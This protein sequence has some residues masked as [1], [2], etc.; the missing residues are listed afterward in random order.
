VVAIAIGANERA[1]SDATSLLSLVV[2]EFSQPVK[3]QHCERFYL[4]VVSDA[5]AVI[6][7]VLRRNAL[8]LQNIHANPQS[9]N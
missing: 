4:L 5:N 6:I 8:V 1:R 7:F 3:L 9:G 2:I